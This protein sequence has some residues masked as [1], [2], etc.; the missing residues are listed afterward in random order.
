[1]PPGHVRRNDHE[2]IEEVLIWDLY[3]KNANKETGWPGHS[4]L[5]EPKPGP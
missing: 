3:N 5:D 4:A 1:M 2:L